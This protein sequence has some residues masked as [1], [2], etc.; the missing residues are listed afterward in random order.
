MQIYVVTLAGKTTPLEVLTCES[1]DDVKAQ[2]QEKEG[3]HPDQQRL[4]FVETVLKN[5][6]TI[7]YY[8]IQQESTLTLLVAEPEYQIHAV[9]SDAGVDD[10][11]TL[12]VT[13]SDTIYVV[14]AK[15][16]D[17]PCRHIKSEARPRQPPPRPRRPTT[18]GKRVLF[19][20]GQQLEDDR[21]LLD[22]NLENDSVIFAVDGDWFD[23]ELSIGDHLARKFSSLDIFIGGHCYGGERHPPAFK[24]PDGECTIDTLKSMIHENG[25]TPPDQQRLF[26][27][28]RELENSYTLSHYNIQ[29]GCSMLLRVYARVGLR[30]NSCVG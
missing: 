28:G 16:R 20:H 19:L 18:R 8:N 26:F 9:L 1:I 10:M 15:L 4:I 6:C 29:K 27:N 11:I 17:H 25:Q 23:S 14:K 5:S 7:Q 22:Y 12:N 3:I 21:T 13:A 24:F 2:I 30:Q